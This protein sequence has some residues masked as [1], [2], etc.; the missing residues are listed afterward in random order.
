MRLSEAIALGS[1]TMEKWKAHD[2]DHCALGMAAN[3]VGCQRQYERIVD[4]WPWVGQWRGICPILGCVAG[5]VYGTHPMICIIPHIFDEHVMAGNF[6]MEQLI[7]FVRS[8]EP[9]EEETNE[10]TGTLQCPVRSEDDALS[11]P[12]AQGTRRGT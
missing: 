8:I 1:L 11:L 2:L 12:V 5:N 7:D 6:T 3:A 9:A 4:K 10:Q